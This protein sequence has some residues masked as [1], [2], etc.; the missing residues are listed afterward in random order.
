MVFDSLIMND[1]CGKLLD[2]LSFLAFGLM[3]FVYDII[4]EVFFHNPIKLQKRH[5]GVLRNKLGYI[6]SLTH[7][8]Q[9]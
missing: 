4:G 5:Q 3:A 2:L 6:H 1:N 8:H 9:N 7:E